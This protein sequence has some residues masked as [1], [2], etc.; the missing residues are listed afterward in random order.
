MP[1]SRSR[2]S[3]RPAGAGWPASSTRAKWWWWNGSR[4]HP[5]ARPTT[6]GP[7][8]PRSRR[9]GRT[10]AVA[11]GESTLPRAVSDVS[12]A[13]GHGLAA[14]HVA[15][16]RPK[17]GGG[18]GPLEVGDVRSE[19]GIVIEVDGDGDVRPDQ[20][21]QLHALGSVHGEQYAEDACTAEVQEA[22]VD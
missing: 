1:R 7:A 13:D 9:P 10:D 21:Q 16:L 4:A 19:H 18:G 5:S 15:D 14:L 11:T 3:W 6:P 2:T 12:A 20:L 8:A 17:G 22:Q